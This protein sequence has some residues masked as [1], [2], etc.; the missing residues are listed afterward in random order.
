MKQNSTEECVQEDD[1]FD[2]AVC[3]REDEASLC[4]GPRTVW[5]AL[6]DR[7]GAPRNRLRLDVVK[8]CRLQLKPEQ[9]CCE[10]LGSRDGGEN[11]RRGEDKRDEMNGQGEASEW[12][13]GGYGSHVVGVPHRSSLAPPLLLLLLLPLCRSRSYKRAGSR[14]SRPKHPPLHRSRQRQRR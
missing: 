9:G 14:L 4:G 13:G 7:L 8:C 5:L 1:R 2:F 6:D 12:R 10:H 11:K 3:V